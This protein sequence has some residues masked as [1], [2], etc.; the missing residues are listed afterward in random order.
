MGVNFEVVWACA[1]DFGFFMLEIVLCVEDDEFMELFFC[2]G[3]F[4]RI[5]VMD[6]LGC[7]IG[8]D[9]VCVVI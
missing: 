5:E 6:V 9:V 1:I 7:G 3:L 4:T 2:F 8:F